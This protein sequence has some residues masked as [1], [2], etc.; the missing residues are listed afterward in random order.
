MIGDEGTKGLCEGLKQNTRIK[1]LNMGSLFL[2][3]YCNQGGNIDI[4][5]LT[6]GQ[7]IVLAKMEEKQLKRC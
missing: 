4:N 2:S 6:C 7:I 1:E 3:S 5:F